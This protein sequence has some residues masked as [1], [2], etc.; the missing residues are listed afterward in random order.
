MDFKREAHASRILV[1]PLR[2]NELDLGYRKR[3]MMH[4]F[5]RIVVEAAVSAAMSSRSCPREEAEKTLRME[6]TDQRHRT[7]RDWESRG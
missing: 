5:K 6:L 4:E 1:S 2:Q 7:R 3:L